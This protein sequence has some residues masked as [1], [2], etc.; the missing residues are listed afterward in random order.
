MKNNEADSKSAEIAQ[1][2]PW[3]ENGVIEQRKLERGMGNFRT[4]RRPG[5]GAGGAC[6][7]AALLVGCGKSTETPQSRA[8]VGEVLV[9]VG[10]TVVRLEHAFRAAI[11]NALL[12]GAVRVEDK[13]G[14]RLL[15]V[16]AVCSLPKTPGW[17]NYDNLFGRPIERVDEA[18]GPTGTTRWQ[19]LFH[20]DG[21]V[22]SR[23]GS[24]PGP[25]LARLRD[26][27]CRRGDFDDRQPKR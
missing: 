23:M 4:A 14:Q 6:L 22:E 8:Q 17:P 21:R 12:D 20:F 3:C 5:L 25:W 27:L 11:P 7:I 2:V 13:G 26:N 9:N 16:N 10:G 19:V 15:E 24:T 1:G 18:K